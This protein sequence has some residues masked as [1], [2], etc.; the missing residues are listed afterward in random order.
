MPFL[1]AWTQL[2]RG[3]CRSQWQLPV[4]PDGIYIIRPQADA[5]PVL[6]CLP[7]VFER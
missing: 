6:F 2:V 7:E 5:C 4:L 3:L 1:V